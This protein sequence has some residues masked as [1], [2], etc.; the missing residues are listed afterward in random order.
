MHNYGTTKNNRTS[1][2]VTKQEMLRI[3]SQELQRGVRQEDTDKRN[4]WDRF[5]TQVL[6]MGNKAH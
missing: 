6:K 5:K 4:Q 2:N 3:F 1:D